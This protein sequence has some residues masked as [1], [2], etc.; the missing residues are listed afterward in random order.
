MIKDDATKD[1]RDIL[2]TLLH[3]TLKNNH[4]YTAVIDVKGGT[5]FISLSDDK[6]AF[7]NYYLLL[8]D[9]EN[10]S[11]RKIIRGRLEKG[12]AAFDLKTDEL[13]NSRETDWLGYIGFEG[14]DG[15]FA[16]RIKRRVLKEKGVKQQSQKNILTKLF[17][18]NHKTDAE[19][20]A[21]VLWK[22]KDVYTDTKIQKEIEGVCFSLLLRYTAKG[23]RLSLR[24]VSAE[25]AETIFD[26]RLLYMRRPDEENRY[27]F[28][29]SVVMAVYNVEDYL[30]EAI[31]SII[32]QDIGFSDHIQLILVD[33]GSADGSSLICDEYAARFPE[34]ILV[35]H[36]ENGGVASARN[37]GIEAARGRYIN[38][39][40][41]DDKM[42][43]NTFSAV[44]SF[45]EKRH[46]LTDVVTIPIYFF[47]A[48]SGEHWQNYKF[49]K[50]SRVINLWDE[51]TASDMS[52]SAS[53]FKNE[54]IKH[55]RFD[56]SLP[57]GEDLFFLAEL[58]MEK[59]QLGVVA[60]CTYWYR[61]I[62]RRP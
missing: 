60:E 13:L 15:C 26:G 19:K 16:E 17:K 43:P 27:A 61:R 8:V 29:F 21:S 1:K 40:D 14:A 31:D 59:M 37:A 3:C 52:T 55:R 39:M 42:S 49:R 20:G 46:H 47:E 18:T 48:A 38:F 44:R 56:G 23:Q 34:N 41:S 58:L 35:I 57:T 24:W 22:A 51:P 11:N 4:P 62:S 5:L 28:D 10:N 12:K 30:A 25:E 45:F 54:S 32:E 50:G 33:D 36:K 53:F 9:K 6:K 7:A 2:Q